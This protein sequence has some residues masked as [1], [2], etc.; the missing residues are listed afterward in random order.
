MLS[1]FVTNEILFPYTLI[2]NRYFYWVG[3][4]CGVRDQTQSFTHVRQVIYRW[5]KTSALGYFQLLKF[6]LLC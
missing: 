5:T 3:L 1:Y 4:L 2:D 6:A